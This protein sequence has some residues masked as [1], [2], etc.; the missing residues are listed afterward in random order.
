MERNKSYY[1]VC[2][3]EIDIQKKQLENFSKLKELLKNV[4]PEMIPEIDKCIEGCKKSII[5]H[6]HELHKIS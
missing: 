1:D 4:H 6:Q 5:Y 2:V 3:E